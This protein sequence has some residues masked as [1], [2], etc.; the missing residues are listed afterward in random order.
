MTPKK[1][2]KDFVYI[3]YLEHNKIYSWG[4][5][6]RFKSYK[7]DFVY[8]SQER[9]EILGVFSSLSEAGNIRDQY[10]IQFEKEKLECKAYVEVRLLDEYEGCTVSVLHTARV[11]ESDKGIASEY[12]S[13]FPSMVLPEKIAEITEERINKKAKESTHIVVEGYSRTKVN[14]KAKTK[15]EKIHNARKV[16]KELVE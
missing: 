9:Q 3:L 1:L 6:Y 16:M 12:S 5:D 2:K 8:T 4:Y 10:N 14:S 15:I 13:D 11:H 7:Q